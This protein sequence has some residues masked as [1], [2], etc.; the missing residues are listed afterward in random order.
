MNDDFGFA[1]R[2]RAT[3]VWLL[4]VA[5]TCF[6]W[7]MG[8]RAAEVAQGGSSTLATLL[9]AVAL[10]KARLVLRSFMEVGEA[11]WVLRVLTD[12]WC[13]AVGVAILAFTWGW[14]GAP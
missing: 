13:L 2:Q 9:I 8:T 14:F 6:S 7:A 5:A 1:L 3:L 11:T 10:F 12:I 4:L